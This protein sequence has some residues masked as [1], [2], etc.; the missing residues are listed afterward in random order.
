[1]A[2][3]KGKTGH[4]DWQGGGEGRVKLHHR[5]VTIKIEKGRQEGRRKEQ[6]ERE[7]KKKHNKEHKERK[8]KK[9]PKSR[10]G[11]STHIR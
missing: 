11:E 7:K 8:K 10:S 4:F 3:G 9:E 6:K 5:S 2:N 1:M